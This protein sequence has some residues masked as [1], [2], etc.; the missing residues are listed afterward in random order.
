MATDPDLKGFVGT[1]D[2][3]RPEIFAALDKEICM[4][5][6]GQV[7]GLTNFERFVEVAFWSWLDRGAW[8][9]I[10]FSFVEDASLVASTRE[11]LHAVFDRKRMHPTVSYPQ[12]D[13]HQTAISGQVKTVPFRLFQRCGNG[14]QIEG[15]ATMVWRGE[16]Y[17]WKILSFALE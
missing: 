6:P 14:N 7:N 15:T 17:Q 4:H 5:C 3:S 10:A 8:K 2:V 11:S 12:G 13:I 1:P 9:E 16:L